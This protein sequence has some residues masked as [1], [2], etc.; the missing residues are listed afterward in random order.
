MYTGHTYLHFND[1]SAFKLKTSKFTQQIIGTTAALNTHSW[2]ARTSLVGVW[3]AIFASFPYSPRLLL[4][5]R[6][7][8]FTV[9]PKRQYLGIFVPTTPAH[10]EP[11]WTPTRISSVMWGLCGISNDLHALT[12]CR[13]I[14][15]IS[16]AWLS[17]LALGTP[18][19]TIS[20]VRR[21]KH[22]VVFYCGN[23]LT[24]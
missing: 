6:L 16:P 3:M 19:T 11:E 15:A 1:A 4:S 14:L 2:K 13:D 8:V 20:V 22:A 5:M 21:S 10:T 23:C 9:S 24:V 18:E 12:S 17:P 7:A